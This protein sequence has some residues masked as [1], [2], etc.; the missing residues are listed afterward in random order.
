MSPIFWPSPLIVMLPF[1]LFHL[2]DVTRS[3]T[4]PRR[5]RLDRPSRRSTTYRRPRNTST[6]RPEIAKTQQSALED[7]GNVGRQKGN[8][9]TPRILMILE[10]SE[11]LQL[12]PV[13][14]KGDEE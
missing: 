4:Q 5:L 1:G 3:S 12:T 14:L 9:K 11:N 13:G 7:G 2:F 10:V 8:A 6:G